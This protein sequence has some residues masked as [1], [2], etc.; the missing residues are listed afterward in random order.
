MK[1]LVGAQQQ[2]HEAHAAALRLLAF[3]VLANAPLLLQ[4]GPLCAT[5]T[6]D[7]NVGT[8]AVLHTSTFLANKITRHCGTSSMSRLGEDHMRALLWK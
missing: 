8:G 4:H 6:G 7:Q 1:F 3:P 5:F 2:S